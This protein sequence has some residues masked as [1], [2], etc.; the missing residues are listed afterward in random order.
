MRVTELGVFDS[1][2]PGDSSGA[3]GLLRYSPPPPG[4]LGKHGSSEAAAGSGGGL[5]EDHTYLG[6]GLLALGAVAYHYL[7]GKGLFPWNANK[8]EAIPQVR[9]FTSLVRDAF[10][11]ADHVAPVVCSMTTLCARL[12]VALH[13][14]GHDQARARKAEKGRRQS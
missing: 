9:R 10:G 4:G 6:L 7:S 11:T 3:G 8:G 13:T 1:R 14:D 5:I 12:S 2:L